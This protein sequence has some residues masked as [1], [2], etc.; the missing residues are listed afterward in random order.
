M[1][2]FLLTR[3]RTS[4]V[5]HAVWALLLLLPVVLPAKDQKPR[6]VQLPPDL[7][8]EGGRK[9]TF[10]SVIASERD[11]RGEKGFWKKL[12]DV[13]A[14]EAEYQPMKRPYGVAVDSQGTSD[15]HRPGTVGDPHLRPDTAQVQVR[16]ASRTRPR[17]HA[18]AAVRCGGRQRQ[19]LCHRLEGRA[20]FLSLNPAESTKA[21][22]AA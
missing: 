21:C 10:E 15:R 3:T 14:G 11:I 13:V 19:H 7:L 12:V 16:G 22:S 18:G 4:V 9:L 20:R 1:V 2:Q 6:E 17:T 5:R 8:L